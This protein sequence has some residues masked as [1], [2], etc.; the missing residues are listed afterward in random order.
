M[1]TK[2]IAIGLL[3]LTVAAIAYY[4]SVRGNVTVPV[5]PPPVVPYVTPIV[6]PIIAP[7]EAPKIEVVFVLDTTG[8]M[9]GLIQAAKDKLWSIASTMINRVWMISS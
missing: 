1:N 6:A 3:A 8:S 5:T 7:V 4:P 9:S 2:I